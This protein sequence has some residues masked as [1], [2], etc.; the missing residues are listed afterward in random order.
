MTLGVGEGLELGAVDGV[1]LADV[2]IVSVLGN[3]EVGAVGDIGEG[4]VC[5]GSHCNCVAVD[6][7]FLVSLLSPL[8]CDYVSRLLVLHEVHRNSRE[9]L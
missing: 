6:L 4:L 8:T 2:N 5:G 7:C 1:V 3:I 9:L